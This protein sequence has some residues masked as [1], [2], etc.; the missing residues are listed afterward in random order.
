[1]NADA[2][3]ARLDATKDATSRSRFALLAST[4]AA[5]SMLMVEFNAYIS[6]NRDFALAPA[7]A[8][9]SQPTGIA[10]RRLLDDWVS[11]TSMNVSL[12]GIHVSASDATILGGSALF[13]LTLWFFYCM[14]RENRLVGTL[15]RDTRDEDL[16]TMDLVYSGI[17]SYM[18]FTAVR[19]GKPPIDTLEDKKPKHRAK[20]FFYG[21][22]LLFLLPPIAIMGS[23]VFD[24]LSLVL[25]APFRES[26]ELPPMAG[27]QLAKFIAYS[28]VGFLTFGATVFNTI[29]VNRLD[30]ASGI[31][32]RAYWDL[33][34]QKRDVRSKLQESRDSVR[35][36]VV[37][38]T[39]LPGEVVMKNDSPVRIE[40]RIPR[41]RTAIWKALTEHRSEI[42]ALYRGPLEWRD[43][44]DG[45]DDGHHVIAH[46]G[47]SRHDDEQQI[48][49]A[50]RELFR[51]RRLLRTY[52]T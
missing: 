22:Q 13:F 35:R 8:G 34:K 48:Q 24:M 21:V 51:L 23:L 9:L 33:F 2:I 16:P 18:V 32:L 41:E 26:H 11:S 38:D 19:P 39:D 29:R 4:I 43:G 17:V 20:A 7:F 44:R 40:I 47:P 5:L 28:G 46:N 42:E 10:Q 30:G 45:I 36:A 25:S 31:V 15:L 6:W 14:R 49:Y 3:K 1:M 37:N 12:L 52:I 27:A 50:A